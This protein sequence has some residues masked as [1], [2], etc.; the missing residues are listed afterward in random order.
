[1]A[2]DLT[3]TDRVV[4]MPKP[5]HRPSVALALVPLL[6]AVLVP[7]GTVSAQEPASEA[8]SVTELQ[9][10]VDRLPDLPSAD[11]SGQLRALL[12][13]PDAFTIAF[14]PRDDG[15][16]TRREQWFYYDLS[17]VFEL[18]D[19]ALIWDLPLDAEVAFLVH[20]IR[21]DPADFSPGATWESLASVVDHPDA[22]ESIGLEDE[23]GLPATVRVG[24]L[25]TLV[26]DEEG[27]LFYVEA[28]PLSAEA[29]V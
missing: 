18:V 11:D 13:L 26:F 14:E 9:A 20:P 15:S 25:L 10:I 5:R 23:Y 7:V 1:M 27:G 17:T 6:V 24:D 4:P 2:A 19:G 3:A 8:P 21:Y 28:V 22:F 16:L 29:P 12:G